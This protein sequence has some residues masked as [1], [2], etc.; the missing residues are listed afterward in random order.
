MLMS[1]FTM[2][3]E[4]RGRLE[5]GAA[6]AYARGARYAGVRREYA[7]KLVERPLKGR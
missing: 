7:G 1:K 5:M 3:C 2:E 6:G 4:D